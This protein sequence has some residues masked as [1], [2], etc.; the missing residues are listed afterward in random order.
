VKTTKTGSATESPW[1]K[2]KY[3]NLVRYKPSGIY[4]AR[5]KIGGKLFRDSL[6]TDKV[7]IAKDRLDELIKRERANVHNQQEIGKGRMKFGDALKMYQMRIQ[8]EPTLKPR[9]KAYYEERIK[10]LL[11]SWPDLERQDIRKIT[12]TDCKTWAAKFAPTISPDAFN[13]TVSVL[14][15]TLAIGVEVGARYDNPAANVKRVKIRITPP[16]LP[17]SSDFSALVNCIRHAGGG[18]S[19]HCADLVLFLAFGGF[20]KSEA[21]NILW[22]DVRI[23]PDGTGTIHVRGDDDTGTKNGETRQVPI[24]PDMFQLLTGLKQEAEELTPQTPVMK[25]NECQKAIDRAATELGIKRITHHDLRHL[26][27]TRCIESGVE[28]PTVAKWLGHKDGGALLMKI[29]SHLRQEHSINMASKVSFNVTASGSKPVKESVNVL[30]R[31]EH[32]PEIRASA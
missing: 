3:A 11:K 10:A 7:T 19:R 4:F 21:A 2:T 23:N 15:H 29:Y 9:T 6:E 20:R 31:D 26:F 32:A 13:H 14:K 28:I 12:Q 5:A 24:I 1:Q 16:D 25:V 27:A 8:G 22:K 17:S 30:S 18:Y